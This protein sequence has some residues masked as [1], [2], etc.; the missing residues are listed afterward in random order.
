[1]QTSV[2]AHH[3]NRKIAFGYATQCNMR[4]GHCVAADEV[5]ASS[6]MEPAQAEQLIGALAAANVRGV[7]FTAGE[8]LLFL[9]DIARLIRRC[10]K[11]DIFTRVVTNGF[12][13]A[14]PGRADETV[15]ALRQAGLSQLRI[16]CSRWHQAQI[17]PQNLVNA[18]ASCRRLGVDYYISFV[19]DFSPRDDQLEDFLRRNRLKYFPEPLIYFGRAD[20]LQ[21]QPLCTDFRPNRCAMN[22]YLSPELDMFACCDGNDRFKQTDFLFLGNLKDYPVEQLFQWYENHRLFGLIRTVGLSRL[23]SAFGL[24]A[25]QIVTYRKCELCETLFNSK[26]NLRRLNRIADSDPSRWYH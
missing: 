7:S 9:T 16:S 18:A 23:A 10:R 13:A 24:S 15:A 26:E 20:E 5:P 3:A 21:R 19:T 14:T 17:Q 1:M 22:P 2:S 25:R 6:K 4:C 11:N 8:P 12:W